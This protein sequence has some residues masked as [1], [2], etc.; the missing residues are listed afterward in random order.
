MNHIRILVLLALLLNSPAF[1]TDYYVKNGGNDALDGLSDANAWETVTKVRNT[2][3]VP[4]DRIY[5]NRGDTWTVAGTTTTLSLRVNGT[6]AAPL[7]VGA[8]GTGNKPIINANNAVSNCISTYGDSYVTYENFRV[9]NTISATYAGAIA[10]AGG[11]HHV[12]FTNIDADI[13]R[14]HGGAFYTDNGHDITISNCNI[15]DVT[16]SFLACEGW[17]R[18]IGIMI[19]NSDADIYNIT[20]KD[21]VITDTNAGGIRIGFTGTY[22]VHN[23][24]ISGNTLGD[25]GA[26]AIEISKDSYDVRV[27]DNHVYKFGMHVDDVAGIDLYET[28]SNILVDSNIVREANDAIAGDPTGADIRADGGNYATEG[29]HTASDIVISNNVC[30]N[31]IRGIDVLNWEGTPGVK[32]YNNTIYNH[33]KT[34]LFIIGSYTRDVRCINNIVWDADEYLVNDNWSGE[35]GGLTVYDYNLYYPEAN[36]FKWYDDVKDTTIAD[37]RTASSQDSHSRIGAPCVINPSMTFYLYSYSPAVNRG[38][39][40]S[41]YHN[42]IGP[43]DIGAY[44]YEPVHLYF[45]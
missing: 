6:A 1:A 5:F 9:T 36:G 22:P 12:S 18:G 14:G 42:C 20:I 28:G 11:A 16:K 2:S 15:T 27:I 23:V 25:I 32:I 44:E 19:D 35:Y 45:R 29:V 21:N 17:D 10:G 13:L 40:L 33:S 38:Y 37:W 8:Y 34:G 41:D 30:Q 43:C 39:P 31:G 4:G 24:I 7:Y 3:F 26:G